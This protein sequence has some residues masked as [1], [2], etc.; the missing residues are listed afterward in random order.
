MTRASP[1]LIGIFALCVS[2]AVWAAGTATCTVAATGPAFGAY[3]PA[4]ST[5]LDANGSMTV[6]CTLT[7]GRSLTVTATISLSKGSSTTFAPRTLVSGTN[8]LN[9]NLYQSATYTQIWG[10]GTGGSLTST[11]VLTLTSASPTMQ[12]TPTIYG[13]IAARQDVVPGSYAD[14][15]VVTVTY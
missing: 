10:N 14:T 1:L 8:Q 7:S 4:S 11:A 6:S 9:Y 3:V 15:I 5:P 2:T 12:A 13:Q